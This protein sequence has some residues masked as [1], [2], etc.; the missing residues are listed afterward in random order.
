MPIA[1]FPTSTTPR[2]GVARNV[3]VRVLCRNSVV[4][5][6]VPASSGKTYPTAL[7]EL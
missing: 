3:G 4:T 1:N 7:A 5:I 6:S 2:R